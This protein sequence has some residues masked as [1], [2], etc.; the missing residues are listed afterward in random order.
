MET[1][2]IVVHGKK[3]VY[4]VRGVLARSGSSCLCGYIQVTEKPTE[5]ED[6]AVGGKRIS[7]LSKEARPQKRKVLR[8]GKDDISQSNGQRKLEQRTISIPKESNGQV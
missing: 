6:T 2:E 1:K 7:V 4:S 5:S 8:Q 3:I